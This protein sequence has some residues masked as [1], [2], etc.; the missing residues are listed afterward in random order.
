MRFGKGVQVSSGQIARENDGL[1]G[2][3][4]HVPGTM[5]VMPV[6]GSGGDGVTGRAT[7]PF[8]GIVDVAEGQFSVRA[9]DEVMAALLVVIDGSDG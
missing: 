4:K 2:G 5:G 8:G 9:V 3:G 1:K 7:Q 6:D